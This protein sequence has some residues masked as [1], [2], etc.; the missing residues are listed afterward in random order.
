MNMNLYFQKKAI[1]NL[2]NREKAYSAI[3]F[4]VM[5]KR[6]I[7]ILFYLHKISTLKNYENSVKRLSFAKQETMNKC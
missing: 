4:Y 7:S 5:L 2:P 6:K 3:Y 1:T